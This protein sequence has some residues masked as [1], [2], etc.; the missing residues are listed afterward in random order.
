MKNIYSLNKVS[1]IFLCV[2]FKNLHFRLEFLQ[3]ARTTFNNIDNYK[4][5]NSE[6]IHERILWLNKIEFVF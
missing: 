6:F 2:K 5:F 1:H 4:H 3:K